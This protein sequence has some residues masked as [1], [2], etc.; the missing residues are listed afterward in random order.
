[1]LWSTARRLLYHMADDQ[2]DVFIDPCSLL[3]TLNFEWQSFQSLC[4]ISNASTSDPQF[5][6][7]RRPVSGLF[8][9]TARTWKL[10]ASFVSVVKSRLDN[11]R[12][13]RLTGLFAPPT[14]CIVGLWLAVTT[15]QEMDVWNHVVSCRTCEQAFSVKSRSRSAAG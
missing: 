14:W 3:Q 8:F 6:S 9:A 12:Q 15:S 11:K 7:V 13:A 10:N 1:M 4:K 5:S 2:Q